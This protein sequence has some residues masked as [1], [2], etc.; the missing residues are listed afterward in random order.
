MAKL[1][2]VLVSYDGSPHSR[3]ALHWAVYFARHSGVEVFVVKVFEPISTHV[4]KE[5]GAI[6]PDSFSQFEQLKK[7]D[8]QLM[9][10]VQEFGHTHG[11][12]ITTEVLKGKVAESI[13]A[14]AQKHAINMIIT[15]N[16]GQGAIKQLLLGSVTRYLVS[17]SPIP[18]LV[19]KSCPVVQYT[20]G[21]LIM[22]T[23]RSIL[24]AYDGSPHSKESLAWAIEL[25]RPVSAQITVVK[26]REPIDLIMAYGIAESSS[27]EK[28]K[29]KLK[30]LEDADNAIIT[31]A[32]DFGQQQGMDITT[33]LLEGNASQVLIEYSQKHGFDLIVAGARSH[34]IIDRL[35]IGTVAHNLIS[36]STVPVLVVKN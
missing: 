14:Y 23:L 34:G 36:V 31:A 12:N 6:I 5:G 3:E 16:R 7:R 9:T 20:G 28:I 21:S 29:A 10:E 27:A 33:L 22:A 25:A 26:V 1:Q 35:P 32:K 19:V 4:L 17:L 2:K 13:L 24:V 15:G 18:V 8:Q 30:E 11:V